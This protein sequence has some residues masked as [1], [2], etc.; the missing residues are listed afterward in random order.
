MRSRI[1]T[2]LLIAA[3]LV[4]VPAGAQAVR[5]SGRLDV[6]DVFVVVNPCTGETLLVERDAHTYSRVLTD[7][8]GGTHLFINGHWQYRAVSQTTGIVY[9]GTET[10]SHTTIFASGGTETE[11]HESVGHLI[12]KGSRDDLFIHT[13]EKRTVTPDGKIATEIVRADVDCHG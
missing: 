3:A 2:G 6:S 5:V 12:A 13:F 4:A 7:G 9:V 1:I 11:T 10:G 8:N